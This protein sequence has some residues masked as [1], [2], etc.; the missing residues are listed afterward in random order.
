M[1]EP[2]GLTE[3]R[4]DLLRRAGR[5]CTDRL[6][7]HPG[8]ILQNRQRYIPTSFW[9]R[10]FYLKKPYVLF[11]VQGGTQQVAHSALLPFPVGSRAE[12][13][14]ILFY[15]CIEFILNHDQLIERMERCYSGDAMQPP[16][17]TVMV[18]C[19]HCAS[20]YRSS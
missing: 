8:R 13:L 15:S 17:I 9:D 4:R 1:D 2:R 18:P 3:I 11:L 19:R 10:V 20:A 14:D 16:K 5:L 12:Q 7:L 6:Y